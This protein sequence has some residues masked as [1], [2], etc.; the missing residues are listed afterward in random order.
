MVLEAFDTLARNLSSKDT[1]EYSMVRT[2][3][4]AF[5]RPVEGVIRV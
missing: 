4:N 5:S 2:L 1:S 3:G